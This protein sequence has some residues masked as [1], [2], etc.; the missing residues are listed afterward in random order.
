MKLY[1]YDHC[2]FCVRA[3]MIIG[4]RGLN[5]EQ[6]PL[7]ND[8]EATPI[9]LVGKKMVPI[10]IKD[11]GTAMGESLDIVRYLDEYA[12]KE[13]LDETIRPEVQAWLN[14]V[15]EYSGQLLSPRSTRIGLPEFATE[16]ARAYYTAKKSAQYGDFAENLARTD[17]LLARLHEDLPATDE[18]LA[19]LHADLPELAALI[20]S[21]GHIGERLGYEDIITFPVLRNLTMVKGVHYPAEIRRY[22]E[23]MSAH[24]RVPLFDDRAV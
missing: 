2:P 14:Q 12:G 6:I 21:E 17:E 8:D 15:N 22:V 23:A 18:Y 9:G 16:S 19:Q 11:D 3:R 10:L 5:V 1:H 13:R 20:Y 7:A 24:S 4:L